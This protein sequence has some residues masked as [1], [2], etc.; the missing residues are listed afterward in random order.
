MARFG[1]ITTSLE[2]KRVSEDG[3]IFMIAFDAQGLSR[4]AQT[5]SVANK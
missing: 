4:D 3:V 2:D 5:F 1:L